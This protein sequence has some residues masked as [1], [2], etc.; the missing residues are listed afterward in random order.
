[1]ATGETEILTELDVDELSKKLD[2]FIYYHSKP[3]KS[4]IPYK[5]RYIDKLTTISEVLKSTMDPDTLRM[6]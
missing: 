6:I 5:T 1:L 4:F 3:D 2:E